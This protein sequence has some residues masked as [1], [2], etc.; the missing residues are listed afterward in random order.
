MKTRLEPVFTPEEALAVHEAMLADTVERIIH[1][2]SGLAVPFLSWSEPWTPRGDLA[3]LLQPVTVEVQTGD[4]L[5]ERIA[6]TF[7]ERLHGGFRQVVII[8]SD[9]PSVPLDTIRRSFAILDH[10]DIVLGPAHDGGYYMI[11]CKMLHLKLFRNVPYGTDQVTAI[12]RQRMKD[13]GIAHGELPVWYDVDTPDDLVH[14]W[15]DLARMRA[16]GYPDLPRRTY[17]L[18]RTLVPGRLD[19]R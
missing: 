7:Q 13:L 15:K 6:A 9:S 4:D 11:G 10:S 17:Q 19:T 2:A 8:G 5:G 1:A 14:L 18:L 3:M 16:K 12:T